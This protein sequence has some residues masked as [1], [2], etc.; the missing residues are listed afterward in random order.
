MMFV[1]VI[2][3]EFQEGPLFLSVQGKGG[4]PQRFEHAKITG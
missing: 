1:V 4:M 2:G 3:A